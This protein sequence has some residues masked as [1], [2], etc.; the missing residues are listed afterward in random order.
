MQV[1]L[2]F[3]FFIAVSAI[4]YNILIDHTDKSNITE[5]THLIDLSEISEINELDLDLI[6]VL[7]N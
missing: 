3:M 4:R 6:K 7:I 5:I 1:L 2:F